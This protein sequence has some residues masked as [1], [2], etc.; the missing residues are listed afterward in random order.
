M[1]KIDATRF[2]MFMAA[3]VIETIV[4]MLIISFTFYIAISATERI[5]FSNNVRLKA[6][7]IIYTREDAEQIKHDNWFFD[8]TYQKENIIL[9]RRLDNY[10]EYS[11]VKLLEIKAKNPADK[12]IILIYREIVVP[13]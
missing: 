9:E 11:D 3:T 7:S 6:M 10:K 13:K 12:K 4:A 8:S 5:M 2:E 1:A